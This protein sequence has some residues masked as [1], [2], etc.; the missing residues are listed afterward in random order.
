MVEK[1]QASV[2]I[3]INDHHKAALPPVGTA[4]WYC[5]HAP[6][7]MFH[8]ALYACAGRVLSLGQCVWVLLCVGSI[9]DI[10]HNTLSL[11][12][13]RDNITGVTMRSPAV[14]HFF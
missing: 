3:L 5:I 2:Q 13:T 9:Y 7:P 1:C 11:Y 4:D 14:D 6:E 10:N 8:V 12:E